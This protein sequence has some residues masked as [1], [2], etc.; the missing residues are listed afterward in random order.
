MLVYWRVSL[1]KHIQ[2]ESLNPPQHQ[3]TGLKN[4]P[5]DVDTTAVFCEWHVMF[6]PEFKVDCPLITL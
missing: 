5:V 3:A 2:I 1:T 4:E 6:V